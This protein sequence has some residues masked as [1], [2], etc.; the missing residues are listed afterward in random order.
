[1]NI[2]EK[3]QNEL[4]N[5]VAHINDGASFLA[6]E[7]P[8]VISQLL[9]WHTVKSGAVFMIGVILLALSAK[10]VVWVKRSAKE[11]REAYDRGERW[12]RYSGCD[13]TTSHEYDL[14]AGGFI[15]I[16][17]VFLLVFGACVTANNLAWLQ[18]LIA[19]KVYLIEYA[20]KLAGA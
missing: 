6:T 14:K 20:A 10:S 5:M 13:S 18:I 7:L 11:S 16:I 9:I 19:P 8:D 1:M 2:N 17:P 3:L 15:W 12:T 4:A